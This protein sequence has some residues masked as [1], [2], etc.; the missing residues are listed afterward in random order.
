MNPTAAGMVDDAGL[1]PATAVAARQLHDSVIRTGFLPNWSVGPDGRQVDVS[2]LG[3]KDGQP[4][5]TQVPGWEAPNTDGM[6]RASREAELPGGQ[7]VPRL[8]NGESAAAHGQEEEVLA[9]FREMYRFL[10]R[11]R[12]ALL[13]A[14]ELLPAWA[15]LQ[16]RYVPR[17]TR[18]YGRFLRR[19]TDPGVLDRGVDWSLAAESLARLSVFFSTG[20]ARPAGWDLFAHECAAL[21]RLDIPYFAA[22]GDQRHLFDGGGRRLLADRFA[23]TPY[24]RLCARLGKLGEG[25]LE[26]Q[27]GYI[28]Q[29][30]QARATGGGPA[31]SSRGQDSPIDLENT[32]PLEPDEAIELAARL[33]H[34][35][36]VRAIRSPEGAVTWIALEPLQDSQV[37]SF[38]PIGYNLHSG[39]AG[40]AL[41]LAA[42]A[43]VTA[44]EE[45]RSLALDALREVLAAM[46]DDPQWMVEALGLGANL[47]VGS[48]LYALCVAGELLEEENLVRRAAAA[49]RTLGRKA[50]AKDSKLDVVFGSAGAVL[51]LLKLHRA[52]GDAAVLE[53]AAECGRHL[54]SHV[55]ETAAGLSVCPTMDG[56]LH[57]GFSH[58]AA[59][60][61]CALSRLAAATGESAFATAAAGLVAWEESLF[62]PREGN[63]PTQRKPGAEPAF[64]AAWCHGAPGIALSR[65]AIGA[66]TGD[67]ELR[68]QAE[69]CLATTARHGLAAADHLCCGTSGRIDV[70]L[71]AGRRLAQ[72]AAG[73]QARLLAGAV[74]RRAANNGGYHLPSGASG[75][76]LSPGLFTGTAGIGYT[77]LRLARPDALPSVLLFD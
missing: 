42:L 30:F 55:R 2:L 16:V 75:E 52:S 76:A 4:L 66:A 23:E 50:I 8:A 61:A 47:G 22:R 26:M 7:S 63:Y 36:A 33:G 31:I 28:R 1:S 37:C 53:V 49:A 3:F 11:H 10:L 70:L 44:S 74:A 32:S 15:G 20:E 40:V 60:L 68:L 5:L 25:D 17:M 56:G 58:G 46:R 43:R 57:T 62:E 45:P 71:E 73:E 67:G 19:L 12:R 9:G 54:L 14:P 39:S 77:W 13:A 48:I 65:L 6:R 41:F 27:A 38:K 59:G 24:E 18:L 69:R 35:L 34:L 64:L 51:A 29:T 72:P 21:L